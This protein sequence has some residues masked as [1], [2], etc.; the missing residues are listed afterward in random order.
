ME[1]YRIKNLT[2]TYPGRERPAIRDIS[3]S[4]DSGDFVTLCGPSGCGKTTLLRRLKPDIAPHGLIYGEAYFKGAPLEG[5][6]LRDSAGGIGFVG[7]SP[8]NQIVTD[9]VWHELAFGLESLGA[10]TTEI[11]LRVAEMANFFGIHSW[12]HKS[13]A[14]LSG[15]QKQVLVLASVMATQPSVLI[16]DEPTGQLDPI[17]AGDF[18]ATL[19]KINR[20]LGVT[21]ILSEHRLE[22]ALPI[23]NRALV[24]DAGRIIADGAPREVALK[25][26][27]RREGMF[28][29]MPAA[30][31]IWAALSTA[32]GAVGVSGEGLGSAGATEG[33]IADSRADG[34]LGFGQGTGACEAPFTVREGA[35]WLSGQKLDESAVIKYSE[36]NAGGGRGRAKA[37]IKRAIS[38]G[39]RAKT[40]VESKA[41]TAVSL[42]DVWFRYGRNEPDVIKG[43]SLRLNYGEIT[44]LMGGNG[45]GK[46]TIL[47]LISGF[48]KPYR[49]K[50]F[51]GDRVIA[52]PQ[53][54][55]AMFAEK[56]VR[57]D[58]LEW[59]SYFKLAEDEARTRI[60][61]VIS[62]CRLE[63]LLD[64]H[65]YDLSGGEQQRAALAKVLLSKPK[66]LLLDEPTKGFDAEFKRVFAGILRELADK[67]VAVALASHDAEFCA[68]YADRCALVF[69]GAIVATGKPADFFAGNSFYTT[70]ANRIA[71]DI[72]PRAVTVEDVIDAFG[73][74]TG[75]SQDE[76]SRETP[77]VAREAPRATPRV[78]SETSRTERETSCAEREGSWADAW[79]GSRRASNTKVESEKRGMTPSAQSRAGVPKKTLTAALMILFL[80][81]LT[82]F[83]G[84]RFF[85]DGKYYFIS[86]LIILET[87]LPFAYLFESR[88]PRARELVLLSVMCAIIVA[89]RAIFFML[90]QVKPVI[91][92][93]IIAGVAFGAEAGFLL[94]AVSGFVSNMF[95]GQGPWTPW[96]M[97]A[98]GVIGFLAGA[99]FKKGLPRSAS[100]SLSVFG[101]FS[102]FA[103][104]G[105]IMDTSAVVMYQSNINRVM[106]WASYIRGVPFNLIHA[107]AT[108]VFLV[109]LSGPMLEKLNRIKIKY[110]LME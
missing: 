45:S 101:A 82:I 31:R 95:V 98:F 81:P 100:W 90:P 40:S 14:E 106:L 86:L 109:F 3:L 11:R 41:F 97:F 51:A 13:V 57:E 84:S 34:G 70:S 65:P 37:P 61:E 4:I 58:L 8:D 99:L 53:D 110:G 63:D 64:S 6:S 85:G 44:A 22:E 46:T 18:L 59:I 5:L 42:D 39:E 75:V 107:A 12:F 66:I 49:G 17:A 55:Q 38:A 43:L 79:P 103:I 105:L 7:Q 10:R 76:E 68:R 36:T 15:G 20:D 19:A 108:V 32:D 1:I 52:L 102:A 23:S 87:I 60:A 21:V 78:A 88:K 30:T 94:G 24:M 56:T 73:I 54:P 93:L 71:R 80:I 69:D 50:V 47:S 92:L 104:Y 74:G 26:R 96:Q 62:E 83:I 25:L 77:R 33:V 91:A 28:I 72:L 48:R 35:L 27:D 89:G 16:L 2:F 67:G 29:A 9:K